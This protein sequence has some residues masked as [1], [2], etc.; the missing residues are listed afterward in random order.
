LWEAE[1]DEE[2]KIPWPEENEGPTV[3]EEQYQER[4]CRRRLDGIRLDTAT[5]EFL[6]IEFKRTQE[7]QEATTWRGLQHLLR[8]RTRVC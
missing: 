6:D 2:M 8:I 3:P 1:R 5:K 4:F 7:M